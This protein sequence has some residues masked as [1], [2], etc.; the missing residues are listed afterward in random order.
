[1]REDE[2]VRRWRTRKRGESSKQASPRD[3]K[4]ETKAKRRRTK[5]VRSQGKKPPPTPSRSFI[6][7]RRV[8]RSARLANSN[9]R[10]LPIASTGGPHHDCSDSNP[11]GG[12]S[13][14]RD[15]RQPRRNRHIRRPRR[16]LRARAAAAPKKARPRCKTRGHARRA[17]KCPG[18][19]PSKESPRARRILGSRQ[20]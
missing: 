18:P 8:L 15:R 9:C 11:A 16:P 2:R 13:L 4:G 7:N 10:N 14:R 12:S 19:L 1:M 6:G 20:R 3:G 5:T 17:I